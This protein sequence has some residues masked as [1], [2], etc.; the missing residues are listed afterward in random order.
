MREIAWD[1]HVRPSCSRCQSILYA[2]LIF[3]D[4]WVRRAFSNIIAYIYTGETMQ[5]G[6]VWKDHLAIS[7][8]GS[9]KSPKSGVYEFLTSKVAYFKRVIQD[10]VL[11]VQ[12]YRSL[13]LIGQNEFQGATT[14]LQT[15]FDDVVDEYQSQLWGLGPPD[16]PWPSFSDA[17]SLSFI[18][19]KVKPHQQFYRQVRFS[20]TGMA[21]RTLADQLPA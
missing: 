7:M 11:A 2:S 20:R 3:T 1:A 18:P 16:T 5:N 6:K 17:R 8:P 13:E 10:T 21:L 9:P 15:L 4:S 19:P 14:L 12:H